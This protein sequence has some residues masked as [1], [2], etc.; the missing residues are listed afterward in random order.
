MTKLSLAVLSD[1]HVGSSQDSESSYSFVTAGPSS[2]DPLSNLLEHVKNESLSADYLLVPGD[3]ADKAD[4][5]GMAHGWRMAH[6][7][8]KELGATV[9][10]VPG[11]HD[12][13]TRSEAEDPR[14]ALKLLSPSLPTGYEAEDAT[15]WSQ[16]WVLL[17]RHDH[18][19]LLIDSTFGFP[20]YPDG[21]SSSPGWTEYLARLERGVIS[22]DMVASIERA[23]AGL[24]EKVNIAIVHHHPQEHQSKQYLQDYHGAMLGGDELME[25]LENN[26]GCGRWFLIHGHKHVPQ[27]ING[28][29]TSSNGPLVLCA[30]SAGAKLWHPLSTLTRNQFHLVM[31]TNE[32][33]NYPMSLRGT[34][35]T[36]SWGFGIGWYPSSE[37]M[38]GLPAESGFGHSDDFRL[39]AKQIEAYLDLNSLVYATYDNIVS[40]VPSLKYLLPSDFLM[41]EKYLARSGIEFQKN[42]KQQAVQVGRIA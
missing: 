41:M 13:V 24:E 38:V 2:V 11:N 20:E 42:N 10:G 32:D 14:A 30:A 36:S 37:T 23:V 39:T 40:A 35:H 4:A 3:I 33:E 15:F 34:V 5:H 21:G 29:P 18:R 8:A 1:L 28:S 17:E 12:V 16:G 26:A 25:A 22:T 27:L 31:L 9:L 7:I 6:A 19:F